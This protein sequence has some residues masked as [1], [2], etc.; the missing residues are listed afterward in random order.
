MNSYILKGIGKIVGFLIRNAK[1]IPKSFAGIFIVSNFIINIFTKGFAYAIAVLAKSLLAAE[2]IINQN[3]KLA[4]ANSPEY[5]LNEFFSIIISIYILIVFVKW[6]GKLF[7]NIAGAQ[8]LWGAF[9]MAI[10]MIAILEIAA[11]R[12]IDGVFGFVP[13]KDGIWFL[14][15]NLAPVLQNIHIF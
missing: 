3:V 2:L 5:G 8:A 11:V 13:I 10:V 9:A 7:V 1:F 15:M 6:I 14:L 4:I 12:F